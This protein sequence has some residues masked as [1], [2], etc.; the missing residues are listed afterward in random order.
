MITVIT[1]LT[2]AGKTWFMTRLLLADRK[3][4]FEVYPN[5]PLIFPNENEGVS[6]WHNLDEVYHLINGVIGIDEGQKL[7]D[8]R[9][10]AALPIGFAEK[11][12]QHRKHHLDIYTTTQDLG[13]ID[14]RIRSNIHCWF[15]CQ[16]VIR[17]PRNDRVKPIFQ[18][19]RVT[20]YARNEKD[21]RIIWKKIGKK[22]FYIS[23][24]WTKT[25]YNTY[26]D[27]GFNRFICRIKRESGKWRGKIYSRDLI[28]R[29]KARL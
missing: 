21:G 11:I 9:R 23:R 22:Y 13:H 28:N 24:I 7:F 26:G 3:S 6:R 10:W 1:G 12:A 20:E 29:G 4:G 27:I 18:I 2:G 19:I 5:Y 15:H 14:V 8:A 16:S 25:Y 17:L